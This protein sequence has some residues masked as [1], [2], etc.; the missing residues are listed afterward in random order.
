MHAFEFTEQGKYQIDKLEEIKSRDIVLFPL[1]HLL[2]LIDKIPYDSQ[3]VPEYWISVDHLIRWLRPFEI[4]DLP[5]MKKPIHRYCKNG[6]LEHI[7]W[8][9]SIDTEILYQLAWM[10]YLNEEVK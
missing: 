10:M 9:A 4:P 6:Y 3:N 7:A 8:I 2:I 5:I 1:S